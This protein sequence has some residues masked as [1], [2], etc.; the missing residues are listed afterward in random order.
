MLEGKRDLLGCLISHRIEHSLIAVQLASRKAN[1]FGTEFVELAR[2]VYL[3][4]DK[5][6]DVKKENK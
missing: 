1:N 2:S 5:C 6:D 4:N 3:E